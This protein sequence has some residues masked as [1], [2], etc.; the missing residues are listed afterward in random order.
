M[1]TIYLIFALFILLSV[2]VNSQGKDPQEAA[3][4]SLKTF[5]NLI[6]E[7]NFKAMGFESMREINEAK[8]GDP[9]KVYAVPLD[10]LQKYQQGSDPNSLLVDQSAFMYP[11]KVG[12]KTRSSISI[13][14]GENGWS[15]SNFGRPNYAKML[16]RYQMKNSFIVNVMSLNL[17]FVAERSEEGL[18]LTPVWDV[19]EFD[20]K[21]GEQ[22]PADKVFS[23]I[24]PAAIEHDGLPR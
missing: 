19:D 6:T 22:M 13:S 15:S 5:K 16:G 3:A 9:L 8:L 10:K 20:F 21:A 18:M 11:I 7:Q 1:K 23:T 14:K 24:L 4:N 2:T 12:D 17:S